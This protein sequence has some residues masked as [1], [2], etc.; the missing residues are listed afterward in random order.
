[1]WHE[2][3]VGKCEHVKATRDGWYTDCPHDAVAEADSSQTYP[4]HLEVC[5]GHAIYYAKRGYDVTYIKSPKLYIPTQ[6][7][8]NEDFRWLRKN[9]DDVIVYV[10]GRAMGNHPRSESPWDKDRYGASC[11]VDGNRFEVRTT[12]SYYESLKML[13]WIVQG[14]K[15]P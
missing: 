15:N 11:L 13:R 10:E 4:T 9:T 6:L 12:V 2:T 7:R 8:R 5:R 14:D 1:M 3:V